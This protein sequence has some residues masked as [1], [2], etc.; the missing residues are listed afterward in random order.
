MKYNELKVTA[1]KDQEARRSR[2]LLL[3]R[4]KP[5][6]VVPRVKAL[7]LV[8]SLMQCSKVAQRALVQAIPKNR[9][10]K[11]LVHQ[12]KLSILTTSTHSRVKPPIT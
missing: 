6:V 3:V 9:G 8:R 11:S 2:Y 7:V 1:N 12:P 10:F 5:L 4:V